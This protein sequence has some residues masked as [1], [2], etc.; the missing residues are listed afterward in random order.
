MPCNGIRTGS[1]IIIF[2]L[3]LNYSIRSLYSHTNSYNN[4]VTQCHVDDSQD[5]KPS[6]RNSELSF[7]KRNLGSIRRELGL[8]V[9]YHLDN[10]NNYLNFASLESFPVYI[11]ML[12]NFT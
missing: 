11:L 4:A 9:I 3:N 1:A 10:Y 7:R 12:V 5:P 8:P 2:P 6:G